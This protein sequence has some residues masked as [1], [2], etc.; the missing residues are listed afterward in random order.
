[1]FKKKDIIQ[2]ETQIKKGT[3]LT[4]P[5]RSRKKPEENHTESN[6]AQLVDFLL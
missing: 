6:G 3:T 5:S 2:K 4:R 1:M